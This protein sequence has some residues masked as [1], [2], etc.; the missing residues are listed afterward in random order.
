MPPDGDTETFV[1][2]IEP[3]WILGEIETV[4]VIGQK[5]VQPFITRSRD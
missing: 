1:A 4:A 3:I 2:G 5:M